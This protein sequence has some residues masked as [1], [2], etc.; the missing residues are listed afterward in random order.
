M[1]LERY[2]D[3]IFPD[4][5]ALPSLANQNFNRNLKML[6]QIAGFTEKIRITTYKGNERRDELKEKWELMGSHCGRRTFIVNALSLGI[7]PSVVMS[8]SGHAS[9]SSMRPYIDIVDSI[10]AREMSKMDF[11]D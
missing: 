2:K 5:R 8:W 9:Y 4:N 6:C 1:I 11:M 10:R 3:V 7:A